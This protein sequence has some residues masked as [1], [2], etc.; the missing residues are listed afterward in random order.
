ML[1]LGVVPALTVLDVAWPV[2]RI[3]EAEAASETWQPEEI[4]LRVW[5]QRDLVFQAPM[6]PVEQRA[7]ERVRRG[8]DFSGLCEGLAGLV[9]T[10]E[11]PRT[12]GA[13]VLRWIEDGLLRGPLVAS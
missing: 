12:A 13:L 6:D 2:H 10:D 8:D 3:W 4:V 11:A 1:R 9:P 7:L 5:R